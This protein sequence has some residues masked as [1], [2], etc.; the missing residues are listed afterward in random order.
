[1]TTDPVTPA[2]PENALKAA[3]TPLARLQRLHGACVDFESVL[4]QQVF[5][6][7]QESLS[8]GNLVGGGLS[9]NVYSGFL[10]QAVA[11]S[12]AEKQGVGL[13]E[14]VYRNTV[15]HNPELMK[16]YEAVKKELT[17]NGS[18]PGAD[19]NPTDSLRTTRAKD[20]N[21]VLVQDLEILQPPRMLS[22]PG[23]DVSIENPKT[24]DK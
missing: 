24:A 21:Q 6:S 18:I 17:E 7:M 5:Q 3:E 10:T 20:V 4:I 9:G 22:P 2:S 1:M 19:S 8:Q 15:R 11:K 23:S 13:A 16:A 14:Q 12:M